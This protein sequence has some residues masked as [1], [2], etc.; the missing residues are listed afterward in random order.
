LLIDGIDW[1]IAGGESGPNHRPMDMDW[2]RSLR[3]QCAAAGVAYH[4]KQ[5]GDRTHAAGGRE[6]DGREWNEF[7]EP[8][9]TSARSD[10]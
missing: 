4:F 5:I 9:A 1:V 2:A 3:D 6:L 7:P 10:A 8:T